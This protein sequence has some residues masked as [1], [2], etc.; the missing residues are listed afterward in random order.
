MVCRSGYRRRGRCPARS[1]PP[2][3]VV[4]RPAR[5]GAD[6]TPVPPRR[7]PQVSDGISGSWCRRQRGRT[8]IRRPQVCRG[9]SPRE[10]LTASAA[11]PGPRPRRVT[12]RNG[13]GQVS[14]R[15]CHLCYAMMSRCQNPRVKED[16]RRRVPRGDGRRRASAVGV[17]SR[18]RW[19]WSSSPLPGGSRSS[20]T[21]PLPR[22]G[23]RGRRPGLRP[24]RLSWTP[25]SPGC[26]R[27]TWRRRS[28]ARWWC[29]DRRASS[30]CWAASRQPGRRPA[31]CTWCARPPGR[32]G[33]SARSAPRCTMP[34]EWLPAGGRW[35]S[36][37]DRLSPWAR[38]RPSP[39][40]APPV[41]PDRCPRR[42]PTPRRS[43][44]AAPTTSWAA[45]TGAG[46]TPRCW[47]PRTAGPSPRWR[48]CRFQC[49]IRL[50]PPWTA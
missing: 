49:A 50:S 30:S 1:P 40:P 5:R 43:P 31:A 41:S 37:A 38:S 14:S 8:A 18:R 27:G 22:T 45:T 11:R 42:A 19:P 16:R 13:D 29:R 7:G 47:P 4:W 3:S 21:A 48:R 25:P 23:P 6:S 24:R 15:C 33:R 26:C 20:R 9:R 36:A 35:S 28:A 39:A 44:S 17:L 46:P 12:T 32:S 10:R 34:Q 2:P